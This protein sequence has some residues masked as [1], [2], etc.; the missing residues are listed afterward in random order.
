MRVT[1]NAR[2]QVGGD[3]LGILAEAVSRIV[4][5]V[6]VPKRERRFDVGVPTGLR[7]RRD[8]REGV[9]GGIRPDG[10]RE[11]TQPQRSNRK[12]ADED[13]LWRRDPAHRSPRR[14]DCWARHMNEGRA[15]ASLAM[16]RI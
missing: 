3:V 5:S 11:K 1:D 12:G 13:S 7:A 8:D 6:T 4:L 2:W 15:I 14:W 10:S 9:D 16:S